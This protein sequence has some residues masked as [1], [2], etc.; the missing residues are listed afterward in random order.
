MTLQEYMTKNKVSLADAA[1]RSKC[2]T[3]WIYLHIKQGRPLGKKTALLVEKWTNG[4]V[5]A[6]DSMHIRN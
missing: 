3:T 1:K 4:K 5:R 2:S 6:V